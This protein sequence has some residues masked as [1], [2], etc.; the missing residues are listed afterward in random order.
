MYSVNRHT[1]LGVIDRTPVLQELDG[2]KKLLTF[3]VTTD[4]SYY[5]R[6]RRKV[7]QN[8]T[9]EVTVQSPAGG[10]ADTYFA[11]LAK[12]NTVYVEG[13]VR[14]RRIRTDDSEERL[15]RQIRAEKVIR[16]GGKGR[17]KM[18]APSFPDDPEEDDNAFNR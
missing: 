1:I 5:D 7:V 17:G 6:N 8:D 3:H 4:E 11:M 18:D 9:H 12:S 16:V 10:L 15:S 13:P 14:T 2:N